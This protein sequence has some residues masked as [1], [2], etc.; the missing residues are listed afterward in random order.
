MDPKGL[1]DSRTFLR[2]HVPMYFQLL[3]RFGS[4][5]LPLLQLFLPGLASVAQAAKPVVDVAVADEFTGR[6]GY[7]EGREAVDSSLDSMNEEAQAKLWK[8]SV[9]WCGLRREDV[10][11]EL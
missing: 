6:E 1:L 3:I 2:S 4:W 7:F 10:V 9:E 8:K 5:L 11:I